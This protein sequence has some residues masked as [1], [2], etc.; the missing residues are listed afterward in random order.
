[1]KKHHLAG[2]G[3]IA[4]A[5]LVII[6]IAILATG[7]FPFSAA[8]VIDPIPDH[9]A[10]DL[11]VITGT[12]N[13]PAGTRLELQVSSLPGA[14]ETI[15]QT[16]GT[17]A[18]ISRAGGMANV[19]S[20][21]LDTTAFPPGDYEVTAYWMNDNNTRSSLLAASRFRLTN[22]T[23]DTSRFP[24]ISANHRLKFIRIDRPG[25]I[26]R[27][28]K[29]LITGTT[30]LPEKTELLYCITQQSNT[31]V[32]TIDPRTGK[33][34]VRGEFTH[35]GLITLVPGDNG[36]SSWS[37]GLDSTEFIPDR[38]EVI[39]KEMTTGTDDTGKAGTFGSVVLTVLDAASDRLTGPEVVS[40][41]CRAI[42]ID[43]IIPGSVKKTVTIT[44]TSLLQPGTELL[45]QVLPAEI[46]FSV[47]EDGMAASGTGA[48][49]V[50]EVMRG[51]GDTG[52]WSADLDLAVFPPRDY[53]LNVSNDRID[54]RTYS[55]QYGD[56]YCSQ[57]FTLQGGSP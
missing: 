1:M 4:A 55:T 36:I 2:A 18:F 22:A 29:I 23:P 47:N 54:P 5:L 30:N 3:I 9:A 32:F 44:G 8:A 14:D 45:F 38:Y 19:W 50:V 16:G 40:G 27:G 46:A 15:R 34:D 21:A 52:T 12:T 25:T 49:G 17:D 11:V 6:F 53:L 57:R 41:P 7:S 56:A 33:Q 35:T 37:F 51:T 13:Y 43:P 48:M 26:H 10:G 31:S 20:G 24:G 42:T 28:E 39:V